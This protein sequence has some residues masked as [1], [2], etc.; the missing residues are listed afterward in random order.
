MTRAPLFLLLLTA[1]CAQSSQQVNPAPTTVETTTATG[2]GARTTTVTTTTTVGAPAAMN[3]VGGYSFQT[4]I[5][6]QAVTGSMS[7]R[8]ENGV[9]V[10][11]ISA[12]G[13]GEFPIS[14]VK[15]DK[16]TM[17]MIFDTPNGAGTAK[18][19]FTGNDFVG[20]WELAGQAGPMTG[21]RTP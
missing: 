3:P 18:L 15:V 9:W 6:G 10:G 13:Q 17:T 2:A 19:E 8:S 11:M 12:T 14:S 16:Q 5:N 21:K 20:G 4:E 1:A 7:I